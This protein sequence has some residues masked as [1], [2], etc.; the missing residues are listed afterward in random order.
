MH[1]LIDFTRDLIDFT[2]D[3]IDFTRD[4]TH[5]L[6]YLTIDNDFRHTL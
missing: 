5:D 3:L 2:R 1:D 6:I 4:L